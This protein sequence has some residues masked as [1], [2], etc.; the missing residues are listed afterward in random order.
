MVS[1]RDRR[2]SNHTSFD[3][4]RAAGA[5]WGRWGLGLAWGVG[6]ATLLTVAAG[7]PA[8]LQLESDLQKQILRWRGP[9]PPA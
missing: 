8:V 2:S 5:S 4:A 9:Q 7:T 3:G 1:P 6:W